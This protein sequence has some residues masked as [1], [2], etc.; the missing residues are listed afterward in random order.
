MTRSEKPDR[1]W[2][3]EIDKI[4][5]DA[6]LDDGMEIETVYAAISAPSVQQAMKQLVDLST[7][8][9]RVTAVRIWREDYDE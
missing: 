1:V 6:G 4:R 9:T 7:N 3:I 2:K 8:N 5:A